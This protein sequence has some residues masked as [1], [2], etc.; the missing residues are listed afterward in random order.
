[1]VLNTNSAAQATT[2]FHY[3]PFSQVTWSLLKKTK[4]KTKHQLLH[5]GV[6]DL[7]RAL[8]VS[9]T[10]FAEKKGFKEKKKKEAQLFYGAKQEK[11]KL[12]LVGKHQLQRETAGRW[13]FR[14]PDRF[15]FAVIIF[16]LP[17]KVICMFD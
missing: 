5:K 12:H 9:G 16:K 13:S 6:S 11:G 4:T 10:Q 1:M 14:D 8:S 2:L 15:F 17:S 7:S 3:L